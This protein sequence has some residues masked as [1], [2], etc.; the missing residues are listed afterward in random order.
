MGLRSEGIRSDE[1]AHRA[2]E[3]I[4]LVGLDGFENAFPKEISGGMRQRVGFARALVTNP[5]VLF[6]DEPFS[7]LDVLTSENLRA[8]LLHLW[9][10]NAIPT[11]VILMVTHSIEE[12]ILMADRVLILA[13]NPGRISADIAIPLDRPRDRTDPAFGDLVKQVYQIMTTP[14]MD[15]VVV[16][17]GIE[18]TSI[19]YRLPTATIAA[20]GGLVE[21]VARSGED[22]R[23]GLPD[24]ADEMRLE[25]DDL[26]PVL[27]AAE[28]LGFAEI[29]E[30]DIVLL[31]EGYAFAAAGILA[32]RVA[33]V[34]HIVR[35]LET[36]QGR[37]APDERF[38]RELE[39][40]MGA[41]DAKRI[42]AI[43]T[44]WGRYAEL[45]EYDSNA[46]IFFLPTTN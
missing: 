6:M 4:D 23:D 10:T 33:L 28:L 24:L 7:S 12:A 22:G 40:H 2:V 34:A 32:D 26:F 29:G 20:V 41:E 11:R 14:S 46:G 8:D 36:R 16:Q 17:E 42:L 44:D 27:N 37:R 30:G 21:R 5:D 31:P 38:L 13:A 9:G 25:I 19:G 15:P 35:V 18:R 45:F 39:D 43:A 1:A 3:A